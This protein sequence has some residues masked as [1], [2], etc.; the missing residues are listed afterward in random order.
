MVMRI[1]AGDGASAFGIAALVVA[2]LMTVA[3]AA[4]LTHAGPH[5]GHDHGMAQAGCALML[6][7][8]GAPTLAIILA[9]G[10]AVAAGASAALATASLAVLDP[11]PRPASL[12]R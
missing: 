1:R 6:V 11:P 8:A 10:G 2:A 3:V 7:A 4:C 9:L 5:E 12:S